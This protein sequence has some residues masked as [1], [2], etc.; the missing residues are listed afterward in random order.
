LL[1]ATELEPRLDC[2]T[3]LQWVATVV[4]LP[5]PECREGTGT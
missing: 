1:A 3:V 5:E 2:V 4:Q